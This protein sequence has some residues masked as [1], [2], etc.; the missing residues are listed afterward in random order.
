M[1]YG[2]DV[3]VNQGKMEVLAEEIAEFIAS[4][5]NISKEAGEQAITMLYMDKL[6]GDE[7]E[8]K[9]VPQIEELKRAMLVC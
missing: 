9:D 3:Y 5:Y 6:R 2:E 7:Y 8:P 1:E 4:K